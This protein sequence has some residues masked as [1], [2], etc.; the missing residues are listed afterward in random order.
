MCVCVCVA[1]ES[2]EAAKKKKN[3]DSTAVAAAAAKADTPTAPSPA[4]AVAAAAAA[5]AALVKVDADVK[6]G[7]RIFGD[8]ERDPLEDAIEREEQ[9]QRESYFDLLEVRLGSVTEREDGHL[10]I[11]LCVVLCGVRVCVCVCVCVQKHGTKKELP[12]VDHSKI[13][14]PPFRKNLY[15]QGRSAKGTDNKGGELHCSALQTRQRPSLS[16][17]PCHVCLSVQFARSR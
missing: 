14:Y 11:C 4:P 7:Q 3:G 10:I 6:K 16:S 9:E 5:A 12:A 1:S 15:R 13:E 2:D 17:P 8:E